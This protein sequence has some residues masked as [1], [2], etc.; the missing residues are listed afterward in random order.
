MDTLSGKA[1][2]GPKL[3]CSKP[4]LVTL[5]TL[6]IYRCRPGELHWIELDNTTTEADFQDLTQASAGTWSYHLTGKARIR[7]T[8]AFL[9]HIMLSCL[10]LLQ[11]GGAGAYVIGPEL[12]TTFAEREREERWLEAS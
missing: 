9:R 5:V 2:T 8:I 3:E 11:D 10:L 7:K 6:C 4:D 1:K 12:G